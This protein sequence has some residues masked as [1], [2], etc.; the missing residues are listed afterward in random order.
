VTKNLL[1]ET[2][3]KFIAKQKFLSL[4]KNSL[5]LK[6][7]IK[8][9]IC[10]ICG[11][12]VTKKK[13]GDYEEAKDHRAGGEGDSSRAHGIPDGTGNN[14]LHGTRTVLKSPLTQTA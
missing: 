5:I 14:Q 11:I 7:L 8:K 9:K 13:G 1:R 12:C 4:Q 6:F 3:L 10:E 2:I